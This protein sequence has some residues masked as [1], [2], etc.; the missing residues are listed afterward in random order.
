MAMMMGNDHWDW[1]V[2]HPVYFS[3]PVMFAPSQFAV[4]VIAYP[5]LSLFLYVVSMR[6]VDS[7]SVLIIGYLTA[8]QRTMTMMMGND[9]WNW[10]VDHPVHFSMPVMFTPSQLTVGVIA[11]PHFRLFFHI[12]RVRIV[13]SVSVF[14]R[15]TTLGSLSISMSMS[16]E[17]QSACVMDDPSYSSMSVMF[18]PSQFA[19]CLA[20]YPPFSLLF[21][22]VGV[23]V[24]DGIPVLV[25]R[26][27]LK[28]RK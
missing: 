22:I 3:M 9:H 8:N 20:S 11:Y 10:M 25:V 2:D 1:M 21:Y 15:T 16:M 23:R 26:W 7:I 28:E 4:G 12:V 19:L 5:N 17:Y 27:S 6:I 14:V 13:N 24:V 18:S